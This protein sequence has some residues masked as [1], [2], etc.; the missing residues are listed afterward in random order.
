[1]CVG[2]VV[3][4]SQVSGYMLA[5]SPVE[6][7]FKPTFMDISGVQMYATYRSEI[8]RDNISLRWTQ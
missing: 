6:A 8:Y 2:V 5:G 1:M 7:S 4:M 3:V